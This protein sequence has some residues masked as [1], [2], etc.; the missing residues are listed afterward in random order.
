MSLESST[1]PDDMAWMVAEIDRL[2][3]EIKRLS[4]LLFTKLMAAD[5]W[6]ELQ[7]YRERFP[8]ATQHKEPS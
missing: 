4:A 8:D 1:T 6:H 5:D 2:Q 3:A 7:T